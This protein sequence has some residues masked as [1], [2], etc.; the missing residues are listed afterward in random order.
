MKWL[1]LVALVA[2]CTETHTASQVE[3][4]ERT[5]SNCH[6][7]RL[8][9]P[10]SAFPITTGPHMDIDCA[11][12]HVFKSSTGLNG[13]H[14]MCAGPCHTE[15]DMDPLHTGSAGAGYMWDPVNHDF[16]MTCHLTGTG[17]ATPP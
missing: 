6:T 5:C 4:T 1:V 7:D 9:H 8:M 2:G 12:C 10:E 11:D 3:F 15:A 16:C 14:A 13:Y 17:P